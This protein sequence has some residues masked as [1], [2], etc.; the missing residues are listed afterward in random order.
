MDSLI[1]QETSTIEEC[2]LILHN[3]HAEVKIIRSQFD[4]KMS[5]IL[6]GAGG[7]SCQL[8]TASFAQ[9][10]DISF[11]NTGYPI[12][13]T[14]HDARA[15]IEEVDEDKFLSLPSI[16]RFNSTHK[17]ISDKDIVS[18]S[19]LHAYLRNFSRF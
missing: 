14:I 6:S 10:H 4:T 18:V 8:C 12:N 9:I 2:G 3:D 19:H 17:L 5:K 15:L 11:V 1:N 13:R 7:A 16:Q